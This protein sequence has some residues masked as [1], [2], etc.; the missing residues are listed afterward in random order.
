MAEGLL[1]DY[2]PGRFKNS[3]SI[4]SAG[5][6]GLQNEP[7]SAEAVSALLEWGINISGHRSRGVTKHLIENSNMIITM[8][9]NHYDL[10]RRHFKRAKENIF[11]LRTFDRQGPVSDK[12]IADPIGQGPNVYRQ[13][14]DTISAEIKRILPRIV[15]L[16]DSY[17][18]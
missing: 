2:L 11:L 8:A 9:E 1:K 14:R 12:S 13:A 17:L 3:V 7:A 4:I 18:N 10:L 6:M 16:A 5:T 15:Q